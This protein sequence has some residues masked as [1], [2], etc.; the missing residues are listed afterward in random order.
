[1]QFSF[2]QQKT[3]TG[4]VS[5]DLGPVAG[6]NVVN[7]ATKA[8]TTTD[9]D[10]NYSISA[11][12]GNVL[13]ISYAGSTQSITVGAGNTYNVSLKAVELKGVEVVGALGIKR[14]VDEV[15]SAFSKVSSEEMTTA[16]NPNAVRS[17]AGKVAGLRIDN[18]SNGVDGATGIQ[19]RAPVTFTR[20]TEA[21]IVID[22]VPSSNAVFQSLPPSMIDNVNV[23]KGAQGAALYGAQGADGVII[24]TTVRAKKGKVAINFNSAIDFEEISFVP[25]KQNTYGQ[26]WDGNWDQYENGGWGELYDGSIRPVGLIQSDGTYIM[27]PYSPIKDN[28]KQFYKNGTIIQ[29]GINVRLGGDNSFISFAA[30]NQLRDF[31]VKGDEFNRTNALLRGGVNGEKWSVEGTFNYRVSRTNQSDAATTLLEL[32]QSAGNIPVGQFDNGNGL[33]G[34]TVY[35]NNPFWRRDNNRFSNDVNYFNTGLTTSYKLNKNIEIKYNGGIQS[36]NSEQTNTRNGLTENPSSPDPLVGSLGQSSA[37]YKSVSN[38]R[39]YYGD[40]MVNFDYKL[41]DDLNL[42]ALVGHNIQKNDFYRISQGG[43]NL[44]VPGWYHINNVLNPDLA[45]NLRNS[46]VTNHETSEF[47]NIDLGYKEYLFLNLTARNSHSSILPNKPFFYPSAGLSFIASKYTDLTKYKINY[48]KLYANATKVGSIASIGDYA[49]IDRA[50]V[51]QGFP[52]S[53]GNSYNDL[54]LEVDP[55][56]E[57]EF[58]TTYEAGFTL[59]MFNDRLTL[60]AAAYVTK[61]DGVILDTAADSFS[62]IQ[63][64][65]TNVGDLETK[66]LELSLGFIPVKTDEFKWSGNLV[67]STYKNEVL[68]TVENQDVVLYDVADSPNSNITGQIVA[69][70]GES[71]PYLMGTDWLKDDQGRVIINDATG[72]P[73]INPVN[74][75][76]GKVLPDFTL[77]LSN[78]ISYKGFNLSFLIDYRKGGKLFSEAKYNMTWSGHAVDTDYNRDQGFIFPNSVLASTGESN[79]TVFTGGGYGPN[80]AIAYANQLAGVGSYNVIDGTYVKVRELAL[81]YLLPATITD[82]LGVTSVRF[83]INARNPFIFLADS[84]KGYTDPEASNVFDISNSNGARAAAGLNQNP[85]ARGFSQV[86][87]YP[88]SRTFGFSVNVGF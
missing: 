10:G 84:N 22:G 81:S 44:D 21:L 83:G 57:P 12:Q 13:V 63:S 55:E 48:L 75:K 26:G 42:K 41:T 49:L 73:T 76:L 3:V 47:A 17:L 40:L 8:G 72:R 20:S 2:A 14:K 6:A 58:Y 24:V 30:D 25:E 67:F 16:A 79:T 34:W 46:G 74:Q 62:G 32:Q 11:K 33:G 87:Q 52:F 88:S 68:S 43:I 36:T 35:Y 69:S 54:F 85:A 23:L 7:Q 39:Y 15:T 31:M 71:F 78:N 45:S 38:R 86:S 77:G 50:S 56:I 27:A 82:R 64:F 9:F 1:M 60:D 29:N 61:T 65:T 19:L 51:A 70:V 80:G 18:L 37:F 59:G 28:L 5:D 4:V 53:S 66:G